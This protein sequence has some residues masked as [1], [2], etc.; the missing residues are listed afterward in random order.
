MLDRGISRY[1][2]A[3]RKALEGNRAHE[4]TYGSQLIAQHVLALSDAIKEWASQRVRGNG[5][6]YRRLVG[7]CDPDKLAV[8]TLRSALGT[9]GREITLTTLM[10]SIGSMAEDEV[11]FSKFEA[12][13]PEYYEAVKRDFARRRTKSYDFRRRTLS[14]SMT[15]AEVE[16]TRWSREDCI[17][18]GAILLDRL[19]EVSELFT[20]GDCPTAKPRPGKAKPKALLPTPEAL[21]WIRKHECALSMTNPFHMPCI[22]EPADWVSQHEGGYWSKRMRSQ[23][24]FMKARRSTSIR[25][26]LLSS[27]EMPAAYAAV[28][29]LQRVPWQ[30]NPGVL[31]VVKEV[32]NSGRSIAMPRS[33]PYEF[34]ESPI[35]SSTR[36]KD[37]AE[38]SP[39][40][41][42]F[43]QWKREIATLHTMEK[44]RERACYTAAATIRLASE[45]SDYER[46]WFVWQV[47]F[48]GRIY[49][50]TSG[51]SPQGADMGR[52]LLRFADGKPL[53]E[54][55]W[56]WLRVHGA[57]KA[58][59]DK[60]DYPERVQ[61]IED[62]REEILRTADDPVRNH[63]FWADGD[64]DKPWQFLAFCLEYAEAVRSGDPHSYVSY[65]PV[66]LDGSC[67]GLQHFSAMLR[68]EVGGTATNLCPGPAQD[69]YTEVA[70]KATAKLSEMEREDPHSPAGINAKAWLD[71]FEEDTGKREVSRK[72]AKKP[73]MTMPYG[74]TK[75]G[76]T[77]GIFAALL[78]KGV[79]NL[80]A[81]RSYLA[82]IFLTPIIWEAIGETV[83]AARAAMDWLQKVAGI[84]ARENHPLQYTS[85]LGLPV[86][87]GTRKQESRRVDTQL[88]GSLRIRLSVDTD[89]FDAFKQRNGS[90]P[91]FVHHSDATHLMMTVNRAAAAGL[92]HFACIH[93]DYG[94]HA[95]DTED[96]HRH[97][98]EAFIELHSE[99]DLLAEFKDELEQQTGINLPDLPGKGCLDIEGVRE[100]RF[101]F[102]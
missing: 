91:N 61:W 71:W 7:A 8:F 34:P 54:R 30:V 36:P 88:C 17:K 59:F 6:K 83:I 82:A 86:Y 22:V 18:V 78:E 4:T 48:R 66:S 101:F 85:P 24:T 92:Q 65:L 97:I 64:I 46:F 51:L 42:E 90:A 31:A 55:G 52:G 19:M 99:H 21:E 15:E 81:N 98:R 68:D 10:H 44:E 1:R 93:D 100:A 45:V 102:G 39:E 9:L 76:C 69:I 73:V 47:D 12:E 40:R 37:L 77:E 60:A 67:N 87:Q 79:K 26:E 11:R 33:E 29:T 89:K 56:F 23:I 25:E 5:A 94:V 80:A 95:A 74:A 49:C 84:L 38:G 75:Q 96:F 41:Q 43:E 32:W 70:R 28:N 2:A 27:A 16:W 35:L 63:D 58:G 57:N 50:T 3:Q 53:G 20:V 14:H 72:I 13:H 62:R